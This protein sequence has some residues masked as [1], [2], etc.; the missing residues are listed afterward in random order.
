MRQK[1]SQW[2]ASILPILQVPF[3]LNQVCWKKKKHWKQPVHNMVC[4]VLVEEVQWGL[5]S[6]VQ[7]G[8]ALKK[9]KM[10]FNVMH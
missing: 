7:T 5:T 4:D 9:R 3:R 6:A 2:S 10:H 8:I 1:L